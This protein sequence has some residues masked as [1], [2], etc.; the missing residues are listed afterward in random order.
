MWKKN[1]KN[2]DKEKPI[3][4]PEKWNSLLKD[5]MKNDMKNDKDAD[6]ERKELDEHRE[7][8]KKKIEYITIKDKESYDSDE[9][10]K[11]Y[12]DTYEGKDVKVIRV[13]KIN[14]E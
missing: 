12:P 3:A 1:P 6:K 11:R 8:R 14:A 2:K 7:D 13:P 9:E 5:Y 4:A 10:L